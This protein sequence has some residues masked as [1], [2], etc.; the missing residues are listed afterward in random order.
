MTDHDILSELCLSSQWER[1]RIALRYCPAEGGNPA[2]WLKTTTERG[3]TQVFDRLKQSQ[4]RAKSVAAQ[5]LI[6]RD[7]N[8]VFPDRTWENLSIDQLRRQLG[9]EQIL[10]GSKISQVI[11]SDR[12]LNASDARFLADLLKG[13]WLEPNTQVTI[14]I[15]QLYEEYRSNDTSRRVTMEK[16]LTQQLGLQPNVKLRPYGRNYGTLSHS[17]ELTIYRQDKQVYR[18]LFDKGMNFLEK[19]N[20]NYHVTE[21]TYVVVTQQR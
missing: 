12:Y 5:E 19:T 11:Y 6:D 10:V 8:V 13:D 17:R 9:L 14:H 21:S 2:Y 20:G 15:Q 3:V 7:T 4:Q 16:V 1:Y 18:M